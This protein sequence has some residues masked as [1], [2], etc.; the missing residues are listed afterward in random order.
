MECRYLNENADVTASKNDRPAVPS[1][2][3][4]LPVKTVADVGPEKNDT[5]DARALPAR[6]WDISELAATE[7]ALRESE[8]RLRD[9]AEITSDWFWETDENLFITYISHVHGQITDLADEKILGH[10][11]EELFR[12]GIY[13]TD[14]PA[15]YLRPL[16]DYREAMLEY[17]VTRGDGHDVIVHDRASPFFDRQGNFKGYRGVG[18]DV[19]EQKQ[20]TERVAYQANHDPLTGVVN[21]REFE[22]CL[23]E[24]IRAARD[25]HDRHVLCFT[26]LDKFKSVNDTLGHAA[27]DHALKLI[28]GTM[29]KGIASADLLGRIGGDEFGILLKNTS[30]Q[31][32]KRVALGIIRS[33]EAHKIK[34]GERTFSIALSMGLA[35][36]NEQT[37]TVSELFGRADS[38]CYR[39]KQDS[40]D[41]IWVSDD[42]EAARLKK[43]TN[44]LGSLTGGPVDL[45]RNFQL[46][47]QPICALS[48]PNHG[49][50]WNEALLRLVGS[51]GRF[52]RPH[53]FIRLAEQYGQMCMIDQWAFETA[54]TTHAELVK[55]VPTALLSINLTINS[56]NNDQLRNLMDRMLNEYPLEPGNLCFEIS[57]PAAVSELKQTIA[58]AEPLSKRGFRVALDG[59]SKGPSSYECLKNLPLDYLKLHGDLVRHLRRDG[60]DL[61]IVESI[62]DLARRLNLTMVAVRVETKRAAKALNKI[63]V[64]YGQGE[65]L[66]P[67]RPLEALASNPACRIGV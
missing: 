13:K 43:Y 16:A 41:G 61:A 32:A 51:D 23:D 58:L 59:F 26:D 33:V 3:A 44:I 29:L 46:F 56:L 42:R 60:P 10:T 11:R 22:R 34:W 27:G 45:S 49:T 2:S 14:K 54:I 55:Q 6:A 53:D 48:N 5:G 18:R 57:E 4:Q 36:I 47:G 38:A 62:N 21:R 31:A 28:V 40:K 17:T 67:T 30:I 64:E 37:T 24:A 52:C 63:G 20:L 35:P 65:A 39:A 9:F 8:G 1:S 50:V 7:A 25:R 12:K 19:T 15:I 66:A